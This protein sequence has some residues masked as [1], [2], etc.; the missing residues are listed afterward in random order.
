[1]DPFSLSLT[2]REE[3]GLQ[4]FEVSVLRSISGPMWGEI[5]RG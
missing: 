5:I 4:V 1:M 3:N 2:I